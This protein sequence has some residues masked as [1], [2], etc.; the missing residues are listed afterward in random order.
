MFRDAK[1]SRLFFVFC[2]AL[3][4]KG[5]ASEPKIIYLLSTPRCL[6]VAF[7]RMMEQRGD[8]TILLEPGI[9][10]FA[11]IH[12][13]EFATTHYRP[14]TFHTFQQVEDQILQAVKQNHVFVKEIGFAASEYLPP[15]LNLLNEHET[16][17]VFLVRNPHHSIISY[18]RKFPVQDPAILTILSYKDLYVLFQKIKNSSSHPPQIL[19]SE[20][21]QT[22]PKETTQ[23]FCNAAGIPFDEK[24]LQWNDLGEGF[25]G[26]EEW[27]ETKFLEE[28]QHWH[29]EAIRSTGFNAQVTSY[30]VDENNQPTFEEIENLEHRKFYQKIYEESLPYYK[31]FLNEL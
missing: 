12:V 8:F 1:L 28:T 9:A 11:W 25:S 16:H 29:K 3:S 15:M 5:Y 10:P 20:D 4:F 2:L 18:Y 30:A 24:S 27:K 31:L 19:L 23:R 17:F 7:L 21:L 6:S 13:P 14:D 22:H 26:Q